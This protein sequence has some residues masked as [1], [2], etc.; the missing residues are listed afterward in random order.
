MSR[1]T[2]IKSTNI[3]FGGSFVM[4]CVLHVF[5]IARGVEVSRQYSNIKY[6]LMTVR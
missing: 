2:N 3:D 4:V 6:S 1:S 5:L